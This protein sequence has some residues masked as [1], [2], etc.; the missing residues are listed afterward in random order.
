MANEKTIAFEEDSY[1]IKYKNGNWVI[2]SENDAVGQVLKYRFR[3]MK[4]GEIGEW[5]LNRTVGTD[6]LGEGGI[7]SPNITEK[8]REYLIKEKILEDP[9]ILEITKYVSVFENNTLNVTATL[10]TVYSTGVT[11]EFTV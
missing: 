2:L 5:V 7:F 8:E 10:K 6:F 9:N 1:N 11:V 4:Y 3:V